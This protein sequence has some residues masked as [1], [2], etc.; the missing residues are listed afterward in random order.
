M[1][2]VLIY[3]MVFAGSALM[4]FNIVG[5]VRYAIS[6][7]KLL[8]GKDG[9]KSYGI[10]YFPIVLLVMFLLGYLAV[11]IFG[12]PDLIVS[13]ILFGG[14]IFVFIMYL[15]INRL[16]KKI[17]EKE[18][19]EAELMAEEQRNLAKTTFLSTMSHEM[20]TP[21]NVIIGLDTVAL[22]DEGISPATRDHLVKIGHSAKHLLGLINSVL[23]IN[24]IDEEQSGLIETDFDIKD[25]LEQVNVIA[26]TLCAQKGVKYSFTKLDNV[27]GYYT[28]DEMKLKKILIEIL[29]NSAKYTEKGGSVEF[30]AECTDV[31]DEEKTLRFT[32]KDTGIGID[33]EFLPK[34][35]EVFAREDVSATNSRGGSGLGL[36]V[37]KK[38]AD[39]MGGDIEVQSEKEKGSVFTVNIPLKTT[40]APDF[41]D[42]G[43]D[44]LTSLEGCRV[45][46]VEDLPENAEIVADLLELEGAVSEHAENGRAGVD[47]FAASP[48]GYYDAILMDLR[49]P[50]MDG[51]TASKEIRKLDREDARTVPI[52]ALTANALETDIKHSLAAGMNAHI[53]KPT[54]AEVLYQALKKHIG[55]ARNGKGEIRL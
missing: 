38:L 19:L 17:V 18:Q 21:M 36:A 27:D 32:V 12:K 54:D 43:N 52:I 35:F 26:E 46:I 28:G 51:H 25:A 49:M 8:N 30:T 15:F 10:L 2:N 31:K 23:E 39:R 13:G 37:A 29:D 6:T 40:A 24:S 45:L 1:L 41:E 34:V 20:R 53:A 44:E 3:G 7:K 16:T 50:V 42:E 4:V 9:D 5:F 48:S 55:R 14:S 11:G 22:S 33:K 47:M